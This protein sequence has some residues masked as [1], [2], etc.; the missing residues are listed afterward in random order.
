MDSLGKVLREYL[1]QKRADDVREARAMA[2]EMR[3]DGMSSAQLEEM[4]FASGFS[5]DVV[6]EVAKDPSGSARRR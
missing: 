1:R 2:K 4:L 5:S 6:E 3:V